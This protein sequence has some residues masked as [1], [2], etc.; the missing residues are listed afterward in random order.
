[1]ARNRL[2]DDMITNR[3]NLY[4]KCI[5]RKTLAFF[6]LIVSL[7]I[8]SCAKKNDDSGGKDDSLVPIPKGFVNLGP[9][10]TLNTVQG[11]AFV[12]GQDGKSYLYTVARG[13]VAHLMGV[14]LTTNKVVVDLPLAESAGSWDIEVTTDGVLYICTSEGFLYKHV[15]GTQN[16][17]NLGKALA[18]ESYLWDLAAGKNGEVFGA[19]Y[20]GAKVFRYH[21]SEGFSDVGKGALVSGENY[22]RSLVYHA[23]T[24]MLY[25]GIGS[26]AHLIEL[27]P[28]TGAKREILPQQYKSEEF[29]YNLNI[30]E[31]KKKGDKL[32]IYLS[33]STKTLIYNLQTQ[34]FE[35]EFDVINIAVKS[36]IKAPER[37]TAYFTANGSLYVWNL[38]DGS[39]KTLGTGFGT[40]LATKWDADG[41]LNIF[42]SSKQL[43][44][45]DVVSEKKSVTQIDIP[46]IPVL[47]NYVASGLDNK[48]WTGGY[49][50]G[51]NATYDQK[52]GVTTLLEGM[53]QTESM[54]FLGRNAYFGQYPGGKIY[55]F[56]NSKPW[57]VG[58]NPI[59]LGQ[60]AG[61]D[62][63]FGGI[64]IEKLNKVYFGTVP[65]YGKN[66]G[67]LVEYSPY[68]N[69][70]SVFDHTQV[71]KNQSIVSLLYSDGML[72]GGTSNRGGLGIA[73]TEEEAKMFV[74]Y[75]IQNKKIT[76]LVPVENAKSITCLAEAP[77]KKIWGLASGTLFI[78]DPVSGSV[79]ERHKLYE[80]SATIGEWK[81]GAIIFMPDGYVYIE[82]KRNLY[83]LDPKT[84]VFEVLD[85]PIQHLVTNGNGTMYFAKK[86]DLWQY[87]P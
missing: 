21:P 23:E 41:N 18:G 40:G 4:K 66:G 67:A 56:E 79:S 8:V 86:E 9:Q 74:W 11:S 35:K 87:R 13:T 24:D 20:P 58:T 49:L 7:L 42:N 33:K 1:M 77:D 16:V 27:N 51:A 62:R 78:Y 55:K 73:P 52:T 31:D 83:K 71:V 45:T 76:E 72:Y 82:E 80:S 19:T 38:N 61:Q 15:P 48:I 68:T 65:D 29:V 36:A 28:R 17:E 84:M 81:P 53:S 25:A 57:K 44:L 34:L 64:G 10:I 32:L 14:D 39:T 47:I 2:D 5:Q 46:R 50:T 54:A 60:V 85:S 43:I 3:Y 12:N 70:I 63:L 22:V 6:V 30:V 69:K 75:P 26:H 37:D 59:L